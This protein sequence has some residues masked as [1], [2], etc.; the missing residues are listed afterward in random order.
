MA[1]FNAVK[2]DLKPG[3]KKITNELSALWANF[4]QPV[5]LTVYKMEIPILLNYGAIE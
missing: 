2:L 3:L 4:L 1:T 5:D